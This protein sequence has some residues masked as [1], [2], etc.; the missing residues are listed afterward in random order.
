MLMYTSMPDIMAGFNG[1]LPQIRTTW[2]TA[3][4]D[5]GRSPVQ[6]LLVSQIKWICPVTRLQIPLLIEE[7]AFS[8]FCFQLG[9]RFCRT[10]R[11]LSVDWDDWSPTCV[12]SKHWWLTPGKRRLLWDSSH[13]WGLQPQGLSKYRVLSSQVRFCCCCYCKLIR[14]ILLHFL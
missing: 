6:H 5:M 12:L 9:S 2:S 10:S 7:P 1:S 3:L 4:T 11:L 8:S 14:S 13:C